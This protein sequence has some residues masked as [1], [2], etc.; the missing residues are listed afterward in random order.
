MKKG[1]KY[2]IPVIG[3]IIAVTLLVGQ[4]AGYLS[5]KLMVENNIRERVKEALSKLIDTQKYVINV[6]VELEILD[7]VSEQITIFS[8]R[9]SVKR[10]QITP[11]EKTADALLR[12]QGKMI[13]ESQP[14]AE[15]RY[16]I[17]PVPYTQLT[18]PT[19]PIV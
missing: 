19:I 4:G 2:L 10:E 6:D 3:A 9:E 1:N 17:G 15:R 11:A 16:S 5:Q 18:L 12:M 8:P 7:E 14:E 13:Q